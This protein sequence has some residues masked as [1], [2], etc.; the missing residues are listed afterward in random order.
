MFVKKLIL[1]P[2]ETNCYLIANEDVSLVID[3]AECTDEMV[4]FLNSAEGEKLILLTHSHF[5]HINGAG[6]LKN[7]T[8]SRIAVHALDADGTTDAKLNLSA[9]FG[10]YCPPFKA[11]VLLED[12]Q[13]LNFKDTR[14][15]VL[16]TPGHTIGS[17]CFLFDEFLISGDTLFK[18]S[19]GR[20]DFPGG[21]FKQISSSLKKLMQLDEKIKVLS[22][23][24]EETTLLSEKIF[25]PFLKGILNESM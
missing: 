22:G 7:L 14:I 17:A 18:M 1:G 10:T 21:D 12:G 23:H 2:L 19:I 24:G 25:N 6:E 9:Y 13:I 20:T 15:K 11:D 5:D 4:E 8:G 16:H 3:P